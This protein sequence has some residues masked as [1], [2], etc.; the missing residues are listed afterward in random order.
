MQT[1]PKADV[2]RPPLVGELAVNIHKTLRNALQSPNLTKNDLFEVVGAAYSLSDTLYSTLAASGDIVEMSALPVEDSDPDPGVRGGYDVRNTAFREDPVDSDDSISDD[3]RSPWSTVAQAGSDESRILHLRPTVADVPAVLRG[4]EQEESDHDLLPEEHSVY[5][6]AALTSESLTNTIDKFITACFDTSVIPSDLSASPARTR[7]VRAVERAIRAKD[8]PT[9]LVYAPSMGD[10]FHRFMAEK[11]DDLTSQQLTKSLREI[12]TSG[13][14]LANMCRHFHSEGDVE[15]AFRASHLTIVAELINHLEKRKGAKRLY[16]FRGV[17]VPRNDNIP[18][19]NH[20]YTDVELANCPCEIK[21]KTSIGR[22][23][24]SLLLDITDMELGRLHLQMEKEKAFGRTY[25]FCWPADEASKL[26]K[27]TQPLV[28]LYTQL[29]EKQSYFGIA[30]S[31]DFLYFVVRDP[32]RPQRLYL[33]RLYSTYPSP[34]EET[35]KDTT[36]KDTSTISTTKTPMNNA[37]YTLY[38]FLRVASNSELHNGFF[39]MLRQEAEKVT[40]AKAGDPL[41]AQDG[42]VDVGPASLTAKANREA[43][44]RLRLKTLKE[45]VH[46]KDPDT[47]V[48]TDESLL[49]DPV[50]PKAG[51]SHPSGQRKATAGPV[52]AAQAAPPRRT[53]NAAVA[54][55]APSVPPQIAVA[56]PSRTVRTSR[57]TVVP[58]S[59]PPAAAATSR[60]KKKSTTKGGRQ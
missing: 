23:Y 46:Y 17:V 49:N 14:R 52:P 25:N 2:R 31:H 5:D 35:P 47:S 27:V 44:A 40:P 20:A 30:S 26:N 59:D 39:H 55:A 3:E 50:P 15:Y 54:Q 48:G 34:V 21:K 22:L 9:E 11:K 42:C 36:R 19:N 13:P 56:Q 1:S 51:P 45:T 7:P 4:D 60:Q 43:L 8:R 29:I 32:Q 16:P 28:Q 24:T 41:F 6:M 38:K 57:T 18:G 12:L 10:V 53:G 33:S 58:E 37:L